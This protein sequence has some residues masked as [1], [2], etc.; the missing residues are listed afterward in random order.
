MLIVNIVGVRL[1]KS[2]VVEA[3]GE[4][5]A[6]KLAWGVLECVCRRDVR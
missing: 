6:Q 1:V 5:V 2:G 3:L 4:D